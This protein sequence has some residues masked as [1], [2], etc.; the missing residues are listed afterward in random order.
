MDLDSLLRIPGLP[1]AEV[2]IGDT[3]CNFHLTSSK[4]RMTD[5]GPVSNKVFRSASGS[6]V[7]VLGVEIS[8]FSVYS[9]GKVTPVRL[10]LSLFELPRKTFFVLCLG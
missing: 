4:S 7:K 10:C 3:K 5:F 2:W 6:R 9:H 1:P 8:S